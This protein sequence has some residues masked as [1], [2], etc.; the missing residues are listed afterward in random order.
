MPRLSRVSTGPLNHVVPS[1][2]RHWLSGL[3]DRSE[4]WVL[5]SRRYVANKNYSVSTFFRLYLRWTTLKSAIL[6]FESSGASTSSKEGGANSSG[7]RQRRK[8]YRCPIGLTPA[9]MTVPAAPKRSTQ[10][11]L[12]SRLSVLRK[13]NR[14]LRKRRETKRRWLCECSGV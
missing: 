14:V 13:K 9:T 7:E 2:D 1:R 6:L 12:R 8:V 10:L 5:L 11:T 3:R 4:A